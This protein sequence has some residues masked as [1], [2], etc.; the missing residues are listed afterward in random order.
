MPR[1]LPLGRSAWVRRR[2]RVSGNRP[3]APGCCVLLA[4]VLAFVPFAATSAVTNGLVGWWSFDET[5]GV[6]ASNRFGASAHGALS[7]FPAAPWVAG[8]IGGA[9]EFDGLNDWVR[10]ATYVKPTNQ[11]TIALWVWADARPQWSSFVK[12]W[13]DSTPGQFHFGLNATDGDMSTYAS[14]IG[15]VGPA[16]EGALFPVGSWQHVALVA[17]G[18]VVRLYRNG[19]A[20][21]TTFNYSG[22]LLDNGIGPFA[23]GVKTDNTGNFASASVPGYFDGKMDDLGLWTRALSAAEI[24]GIY[25]SGLAGQPLVG[26]GDT[27]PS[28]P[29]IVQQPQSIA[30]VAG[31]SAAF[32]VTASGT[33]PLAYQWRKDG[34]NLAGATNA[35]FTLAAVTT[36]DAGGYTA[37]VTNITGGATSAVAVLVV[38]TNVTAIQRGLVGWWKFDSTNGTTAFD[39]TVYTNH[40]VLQN[41]PAN[42]SQWVAGRI[43]GALN[44]RGPTFGD[45]VRVPNYPKPTTGMTVSAWVWADA[46]PVWASIAKTWGGGQLF[47]FGLEGSGGQLGNYLQTPAGQPNTRETVPLPLGSWQHV[48]FTA[49]GSQLR[50]YRNGVQVASVG[51]SGTLNPVGNARL[52]IGVKLNAAGTPEFGTE[53][54]WQGRIDDLGVWTRALS[55]AELLAIYTAGLN[56]LDLSQ[57]DTTP[58]PGGVLISEFMAA[59]SGSLRDADGDSPDWIELYNGLDVPVN[60]AGWSLTDATNNLRKWLLPATNL[61]SRGFLI[62]FAS[63]KD[64]AVA[65]QELHANFS[66]AAS[67]EYLALV[68]PAT[69]VVSEF[70][71][72]FALQVVNVSYGFARPPLTNEPPGSSNYLALLRYF[73]QPT[74]GS[75]NAGGVSVLGPILSDV[76]HSPAVPF[77]ADNL[78]VTARVAAAFA[79]VGGVTLRYRVMFGPEVSLPMADDGASGDGLAGDG[80]YGA[81][82][83]AAASVPGQMVRYYVQAF[84]LLN[85]TSRWPL[86]LD[87]NGSPEYQGTV[88]Q[89]LSVTSALPVMHWFAQDTAAA[90]TDAGTRCSVFYDGELYDNI[91]VRIRGGTARSWPKKSYKLEMNEGHYFRVHPGQPRV[92]EFDLNATYTD[93]SYN[94]A[95]LASEFGRDAGLPSPETFHVHLRQNGAFYSVAL[96][97]EQPDRDFLRRWDLD[98]DSALYKCGPGSTYDTVLS[99][100]KKTRKTEGFEDAQALL[101]GLGLGGAALEQFVFDHVD[102][103]GMVNFLATVVISQ[104]I[105]ASDKNHY[106][107]R[108]TTGSGE[109]RILPWDLD[110]TFGPDALNTDAIVYNQQDAVTP[111]ATSHPFLGARPYLLHGGKYNRFLEA[112]VA[113][114]RTRAM[115]LR[116][117]RTLTDDFLAGGYFT[118]RLNQ[119]VPLLNADVTADRARWGG[120]AHFPGGA[121]TLQ[122]AN[123]RIRLEYLNRRIGYLTLSN[124]TGV[125]VMPGAQPTNATVFITGL[126]FNPTNGI[127]DQEYLCLTNANSFA[128]DLTGWRL[129]GEVDH[130]FKPGTV[131]PANSVLYLSPQAAEFRARLSSPRGGESLFVQGN[132]R[133]QLSARGGALQLTDARS[134]LVQTFSYAGAPSDAQRFLRITELMY[135]PSPLPGN[136]NDAQEFEFIELKNLGTNALDLRGLRFRAGIDFDFNQSSVS[137][138]APGAYLVLAENTNAL[139]QRYGALPVAGQ[140]LG[141]LDNNTERLLLEDATGEHILEFDYEDDW[142]R[143][144]DGRGFSLVVA[145]EFA[146]HTAWDSRSNWLASACPGGSPGGPE[147][148]LPCDADSDGLADRWEFHYATNLTTLSAAGDADG[149]GA[150]DRDELLAGTHPLDASDPLRITSVAFNAAATNVTIQFLAGANR[151]YTVHGRTNVALGDWGPVAFVPVAPTNRPVALPLPAATDAPRFYRVTSP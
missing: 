50:I 5:S 80:V 102:V 136:T 141:N 23:I 114:P 59:N 97:V 133:G 76:N 2:F 20:V 125:G 109:W 16:R 74:P 17:D 70:R 45:Y 106:L 107:Y 14:T 131:L 1:F 30:R 99:F 31:E 83:P 89:N 118:N 29:A 84:D 137:N 134:N 56:G 88:V 135:N 130:D 28:A 145:N 81:A 150:S 55:A 132:Y 92:S 149:D 148:L 139:A 127:Q 138:L 3:V 38:T 61:A 111:H 101:D 40:G 52:G 60:L 54:F 143:A 37:V 25:Q 65:G 64:R 120:N 63:G 8:R 142:Q 103:P 113:V 96:F 105:D 129:R 144:S 108:D 151:G 6:I 9:L 90:E 26:P 66:L 7:N 57:A 58:P 18:S 51:Y 146:V 71:P 43:G 10:V 115:L 117:I 110:L 19:A 93:K 86:F 68:D 104:N 22:N 91:Y 85:R 42:D 75:V 126:E 124:I 94:R 69:N 112:I 32:T 36:N 95:V 147:P 27:P 79:P 72:V 62:V 67:G 82:I 78:V 98:A 24:L 46:R 121:Y 39:A 87:P 100:E 49:D 119:L 47:H 116:R 35:T 122:Q 73:T 48:A 15:A 13:G 44:F 34:T 21:G 140:Y 11:L 53:G 77:D 33:P 4:A 12:N 41:F 123:D 128:V